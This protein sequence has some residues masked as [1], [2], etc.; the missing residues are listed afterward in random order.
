M[1]Y[2]SP[3]AEFFRTV[4]RRD[5]A[6]R[7]RKE[8][9][10][11][12][13]ETEL[14]NFEAWYGAG[15]GFWPGG[16]PRVEDVT[17][18]TIT[19]A[20]AGRPGVAAATANKLR[21][22]LVALRNHA[23]EANGLAPLLKVAKLKEPKRKPSA[24]SEQRFGAMLWVADTLRGD[25]GRVT[26]AAFMRAY[27]LTQWNSGARIAALMAVRW[28]SVDL[29][30]GLLVLEADTA[31]DAE[32]QRI[33]L[34]PETVEALAQ[35]RVGGV[36][37]PFDHWPYD[38]DPVKR[39]PFQCL[40]NLLRKVVYVAVFAPDAD[41]NAVTNETAKKFVGAR[42]LSHK[43]RRTFGTMIAIKEGIDAAK[44]ML[45]HS[46]ISTTLRYVDPSMMPKRS[47]RAILGA[48]PKAV[49]PQMRLFAG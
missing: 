29:C 43:I 48:V 17:R 10:C 49:S 38:R 44:E 25:C 19:A 45:G 26:L 7:L 2:A 40:T 1:A 12:F 5:Q 34:L 13:Y 22:A 32:D 9:S 47:A 16:P 37:G 15:A 46:H 20:M 11:Q 4:Y 3:L 36:E 14:H 41:V 27:L 30:D 23:T 24:W 35:L 18:E 6:A 21:R 33:T 31:K 42:E 8:T 39:R 28:G